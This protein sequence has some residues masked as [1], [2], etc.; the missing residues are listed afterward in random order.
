MENKIPESIILA[1]GLL[2][3]GS[4]IKGGIKVFSERDRMV[5]VKGLSEME[6][7]ANRVI[8]PLLFKEVGNDLLVLYDN[9]KD[10]NEAIVSF[11]KKN[12][13]K[14]EEISISAP[15]VIDMEADRY[16]AVPSPYRYN[17]TSVITVMSDNVNLVRRLM[18]EQGELLQK[19]I[20]VGGD[21]YQY[22]VQ[23]L[24]TGLNDI[25]PR[26][27]EEATKN[28][29]AAAEKFARDSNSK[30]GKIKSANQGQFTISDRDAN[31]PYIKNI[32]VVSTIDY[33]LK[34]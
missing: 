11:L 32:R 29:R 30:L 13:I 12:G 28:A 17:I 10:K 3:L 5:S 25:K 24:F 9:L 23:F 22:N 1:I 33:Y 4:M 2:L 15:Q 31:T 14:D 19:G 21:E 27:I 8:W 26:M 16:R 7:Q 6:V 20:A 18:S 34:D